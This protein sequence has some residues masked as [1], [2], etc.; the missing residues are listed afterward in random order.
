MLTQK[1]DGVKIY[2]MLAEL[3]FQAYYRYNV[4]N[5][6]N[7]N[8]YINWGQFLTEITMIHLRKKNMEKLIWKQYYDYTENNT[9]PFYVYVMHDTSN[10]LYK[11]GK[12]VNPHERLN[13]FKTANASIELLSYYPGFMADE[14]I[15]H[16]K[17][18][19]YRIDREW[20][21]LKQKHLNQIDKYFKSKP[22]YN[23]NTL[24]KDNE[25]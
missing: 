1:K 5:Y 3:F 25:S 19:K 16:L 21:K 6:K 13:N 10:N 12:A 11:I 15:I 17:F 14:K 7:K 23:E 20:F 24:E 2:G 8:D 9:I 22:Y 4:D 18:D